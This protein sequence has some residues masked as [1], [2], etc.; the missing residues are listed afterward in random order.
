MVRG[1]GISMGLPNQRVSQSWECGPLSMSLS[2]YL[3]YAIQIRNLIPVDEEIDAHDG[4]R[5]LGDSDF[6]QHT[7]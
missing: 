1:D 4:D 7:L 5:S 2:E 3:F 6:V